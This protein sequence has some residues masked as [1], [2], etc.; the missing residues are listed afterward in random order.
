MPTFA[1]FQATLVL[2]LL[3]SSCERRRVSVPA[4]APPA[5]PA[6]SSVPQQAQGNNERVVK[7]SRAGKKA[8]SS[9]KAAA[10]VPAAS[11]P[12]APASPAPKLGDVPTAE[13]RTKYNTSIDQSL[14]HAQASLNRIKQHRLTSAQADEAEQIANFMKQAQA[15]RASDLEGAKSL[16]ERAEV[17][18]KDLAGAV[19]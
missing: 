3:G 6:A 17:L 10:S 15:A 19:H 8:S 18:A 9:P 16:A 11:V 14:A 4:P 7:S 12:A 13:E 5:P 2:L 1:R